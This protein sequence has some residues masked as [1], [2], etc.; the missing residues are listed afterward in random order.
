MNM[1]DVS[2]NGI[3]KI[4]FRTLILVPRREEWSRMRRIRISLQE[5]FV[6]LR[7]Y[8]ISFILHDWLPLYMPSTQHTY[9]HTYNT[10]NIR[11]IESRQKT[12]FQHLW[13]WRNIE[14]VHIS[15]HWALL[16]VIRFAQWCIKNL[17][18]R[19][20]AKSNIIVRVGPGLSSISVAGSMLSF[21]NLQA[22]L[23]QI[24]SVKGE[25]E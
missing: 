20:P 18:K 5:L 15:L 25:V 7:F 22:N 11:L 10:D 21:V 14:C 24:S 12:S 3:N 13:W 2:H 16:S 4:V 9:M 23:A 19:I 8:R 1:L 6:R 17:R